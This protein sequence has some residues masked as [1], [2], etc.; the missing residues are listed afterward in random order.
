MTNDQV[1]AGTAARGVVEHSTLGPDEQQLG[2]GQSKEGLPGDALPMPRPWNKDLMAEM[3]K[4]PPC[5]KPRPKPAGRWSWT[6]AQPPRRARFRRKPSWS[7]GP[8]G[9][10]TG[11]AWSPSVYMV[12]CGVQGKEALQCPLLVLLQFGYACLEMGDLSLQ[13][14]NLIVVHALLRGY[15]RFL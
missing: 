4:E 1:A 6:Q 12:P 5:S 10:S 11:G 7:N 3:I 8:P 14:I 13:V 2:T 15:T 9:R